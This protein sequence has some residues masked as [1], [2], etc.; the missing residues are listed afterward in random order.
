MQRPPRQLLKEKTAGKPGARPLKWHLGRVRLRRW[1]RGSSGKAEGFATGRECACWKT[2]T[3][4]G[5]A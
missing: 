1:S 5:R 3:V 2:A 4:H